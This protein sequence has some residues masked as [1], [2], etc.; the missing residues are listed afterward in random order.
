MKPPKKDLMDKALKHYEEAS[1]A[2]HHYNSDIPKAI[3]SYYKGQEPKQ[4]EE[5]RDI[6]FIKWY[7]GMEEEK[8]RKAY[9]R[10]TKECL[11][12]KNI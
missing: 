8:T 7:S 11:N 5:I 3:E 9:N 2:V 12:S 6:N 4:E 10:Y 1:F